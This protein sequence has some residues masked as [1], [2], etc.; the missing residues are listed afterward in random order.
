MIVVVIAGAFAT[1]FGGPVNV[2]TAVV[3]IVVV[4]A[5]VVGIFGWRRYRGVR[6]GGSD[7][8]V[9]RRY[10]LVIIA[11]CAGGPLVA[12]MLGMLLTPG[13]AVSYGVQFLCAAVIYGVGMTVLGRSDTYEQGAHP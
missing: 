12:G 6:I 8:G 10:R 1:I 7:R 3:V 5:M 2:A 13:T 4:V 9:S 11:M